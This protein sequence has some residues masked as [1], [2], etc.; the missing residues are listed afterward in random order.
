MD[1]LPPKLQEGIWVFIESHPILWFWIAAALLLIWILKILSDSIPQ[2][3]IIKSKIVTPLAQWVRH[4]LL[5]KAAIKSDIQGH[6]NRE[7]QLIKKELPFG[8]IKEMEINW[9]ANE[10]RDDL[11]NSG[12]T[13]IRLRPLADQDRNFVNATHQFLKRSF[14]PKTG[15]V[16]PALHRDASVLYISAK[17]AK[18][19]GPQ[20]QSAFEDFILE[21]AIQRTKAIP[22]IIEAYDEIDRRGF[23]TG[24]FLR[25]LHE[26]AGEV[27]LTSMRA[28]VG[29]EATAILKH[30]RD[31]IKAFD[32]DDQIPSAGWY[33]IGPV[34]RYG[35]LLV[36]HPGK[37][38]D[39]PDP[40]VNRAREKL[41]QGA[42]RLYI[43]GAGQESSFAGSVIN[44]VQIQIPDWKLVEQ[45]ETSFDYRGNHG[46][47]GALFVI[48]SNEK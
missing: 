24:A 16:I 39:G 21:P 42:K 15:A 40:Y 14:F 43:F 1:N 46:G 4:R 37:T 48:Q 31:F 33:N 22:K 20:A 44:A 18:R 8:W 25:E 47:V 17:I 9:I 27:R 41:N 35:L 2:L 23:F 3:E 29:G 5:V 36:A 13:I 10:S 19:R 11:L 6:V 28:S 32:S 45:F 30:V 38:P 34:S 12:E 26:V 7:L